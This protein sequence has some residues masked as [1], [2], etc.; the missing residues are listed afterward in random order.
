MAF[1][2]II[3]IWKNWKWKILQAATPD[4]FV[5]PECT[6]R[7]ILFL[8]KAVSVFFFLSY[9]VVFRSASH[10]LQLLCGCETEVGE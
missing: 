3:G 9:T 5:M 8:F 6:W 4:C 1:I 2:P 10:L 7:M